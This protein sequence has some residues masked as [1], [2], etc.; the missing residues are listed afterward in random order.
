M[1]KL[2][3]WT[4]LIIV[5][6]LLLAAAGTLMW[7]GQQR[8][9]ADAVQSGAELPLEQGIH[10]AGSRLVGRHEGKRQWEIASARVFDDGDYVDMNDISEVIIFHDAEPYFYVDA[11]EGRWHRPTNDLELKGEIIATGPDDFYLETTVLIWK[12]SDELLWAPEP[13]VLHYQG[14]VVHADTMYAYPNQER[15]KLSG[16]VQ[17]VEDGLV[18]QMPELLYELDT[19]IMHVYGSATLL[20]ERKG[21]E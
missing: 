18:W 6:T 12:A 11:D 10:I 15:V 8:K 1:Y 3:K 2:P 4:L 17:I 14:A 9:Q 19:E 21:G 20:L 13:V 16:S 5:V 7:H